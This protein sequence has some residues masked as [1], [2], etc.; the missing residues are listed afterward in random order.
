MSRWRRIHF[1][2]RW[3][4]LWISSFGDDASAALLTFL[5][6][7]ANRLLLL[8]FLLFFYSSSFL[9]FSAKVHQPLTLDWIS[10]VFFLPRDSLLF[11]RGRPPRKVGGFQQRDRFFNLNLLLL[12]DYT[13]RPCC[14][15]AIE[16]GFTSQ[17]CIIDL[18]ENERERGRKTSGTNWKIISATL[19]P[20]SLFDFLFL[21]WSS[22]LPTLLRRAFIAINY[23]LLVAIALT[24]T[25]TRG[26]VCEH[27]TK[28]HHD[29]REKEK[30]NTINQFINQR[31]FFNFLFCFVK[32]LN[33][34]L[35]L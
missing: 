4:F 25:L 9:L 10:D 6:C 12:L 5:S 23:F 18:S 24:H 29:Q 15:H 22:V 14:S 19:F 17:L 2:T 32:P 34:L 28:L 20:P 16:T 35:M 7:C 30:K 33:F 27:H 1:C 21:L 11:F 31:F 26:F 13:A 8:L 3:S